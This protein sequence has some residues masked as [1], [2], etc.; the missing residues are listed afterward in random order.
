MDYPQE[1]NSSSPSKSGLAE[2]VV[3]PDCEGSQKEFNAD[4]VLEYLLKKD[5]TLENSEKVAL[6]VWEG[7]ADF[8][9]SHPQRN[10]YADALMSDV[11]AALTEIILLTVNEQ[12][13]YPV[14]QNIE[15]TSEALR[16]WIDDAEGDDI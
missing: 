3:E 13:N 11:T 10:V 4:D 1:E 2:S 6:K 15:L 12:L 7:W 5:S 8:E 16:I 14:N 9:R